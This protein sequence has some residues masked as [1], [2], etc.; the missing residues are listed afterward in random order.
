MTR[1]IWV[2]SR[3]RRMQIPNRVDR[4]RIGDYASGNVTWKQAAIHDTVHARALDRHNSGREHA[5]FGVL[6]HTIRSDVAECGRWASVVCYCELG[7]RSIALPA[8]LIVRASHPSIAVL[9]LETVSMTL[10]QRR[11]GD[12]CLLDFN[13]WRGIGSSSWAAFLCPRPRHTPSLRALIAT[14]RSRTQRCR[15]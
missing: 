3:G 14:S 1:Q 13:E 15:E 12:V 5:P 8:L 7:Q 9:R 4:R 11:G 6:L 10:V 2:K